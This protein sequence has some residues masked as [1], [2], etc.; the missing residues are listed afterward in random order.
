MTLEA[1]ES[2]NSLRV[3]SYSSSSAIEDAG[4]GTITSDPVL[5]RLVHSLLPPD[6]AA[7]VL[8]GYYTDAFHSKLL[9]RLES[10]RNGTTVGDGYQRELSLPAWRLRRVASFVDHNIDQS[11]SLSCL[12]QAAGLSRMHF[13]ALFRRATGFRPHYYVTQRRIERAKQ[14]LSGSNAPI[15]EIALSVGFQSQAHFTTVFKRV[16]GTTPHRWRLL[17]CED[18][19]AA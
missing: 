17:Q 19:L 9:Q 3:L 5:E 14:M 2:E 8:R 16:A 1:M 7:Q 15:V 12:A 6:E 18:D 11:L 13:A 10:I 4:D